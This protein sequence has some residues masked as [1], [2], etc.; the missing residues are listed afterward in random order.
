MIWH[1]NLKLAQAKR[2]PTRLPKALSAL[3]A[4]LIALSISS[5]SAETL[6]P[7]A[8]RTPVPAKTLEAWRGAPHDMS[9]LRDRVH[10]IVFWASWCKPCK[11]EIRHILKL[12]KRFPELAILLIST[13]NS[14][15]IA[16]VGTKA[17][18]WERKKARVLLDR[19]G[20]YLNLFNN[21]SG[22]IPYLA[23]SD[24]QGRIA[25]N[26]SGYRPGDEDKIGE[27]IEQLHAEP[28]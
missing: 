25:L 4:L 1:L 21:P 15:T 16:K 17:R 18:K 27:A 8:E 3:S 2:L 11:A 19:D 12:K 6:I 5:A 14:Q 23:L 9:A 13:D 22:T 10:V 26:K 7:Q 28:R 24:R 20:S